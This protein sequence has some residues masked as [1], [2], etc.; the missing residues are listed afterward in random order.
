MKRLI[1]LLALLP[2]AAFAMPGNGPYPLGGLVATLTDATNISN[3]TG[4][5]VNLSG[6]F[7]GS[8]SYQNGNPVIGPSPLFLGVGANALY[9]PDGSPFTYATNSHVQMSW[10]SGFGAMNNTNGALVL[11]FLGAGQGG[12]AN[13]FG[14]PIIDRFGNFV[15]PLD[16]ATLQGLSA[17][18]FLQATNNL[19]I[20]SG[21]NGTGSAAAGTGGTVNIANGGNAN[22]G[23]AGQGGTVNIANSGQNGGPDAIGGTVNIATSRYG[24]GGTVNLATTSGGTAGTVNAGNINAGNVAGTFIGNGSQLTGLSAAQIAGLPTTNGLVTASVTNGLATVNYVNTATNSVVQTNDSRALNL[25]NAGNVFGG[26]QQYVDI[27]LML[28]NPA[29]ASSGYTP[30]PFFTQPYFAA[31]NFASYIEV[32]DWVTNVVTY[33]KYEW[34]GNVPLTYTNYVR[35]A[36]HMPVIGREQGANDCYTV[37]TIQPTNMCWVLA[38]N[39]FYGSSQLGT[40]TVYKNI[41]FKNNV[42]GTTTN[43]SGQLSI[44]QIRQFRTGEYS[45]NNW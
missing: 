30:S 34:T 13:A 26:V 41:V 38:T 10:P 39:S 9:Y 32:P 12:L 18:N 15:N 25:G 16:A 40:N 31:T 6:T 45:G 27:P 4:T 11:P 28:F 14:N 43:N 36:T 19:T 29:P 22:S 17:T 2:V 33:V 1:A 5:N 23:P 42:I 24:T 8:V 20:A 7:T 44:I 3:A 21:T 37:F 35:S